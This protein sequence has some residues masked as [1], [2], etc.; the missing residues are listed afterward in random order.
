MWLLSE[1]G[2]QIDLGDILEGQLEALEVGPGEGAAGELLVPSLNG[3]GQRAPGGS[4]EGQGLPHL[5]PVLLP[6][7]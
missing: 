6:R 3:S 5:G 2:R 7:V 4:V 1:L